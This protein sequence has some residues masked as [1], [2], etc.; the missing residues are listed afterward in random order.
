MKEEKPVVSIIVRTKD[1]L[2]LLKKALQSV[3]VQTYRPIEIILVNDG[4]C[5][6]D[7]NELKG[8]VGNIFLHY[9]RLEK[10]TGRAHAGN[11]GIENAKGEYIGFLDDDDEFYP[12][13]LAL[14]VSVLEQIDYK[15][16][17]TDSEL[18]FIE[19]DSEKKEFYGKEKKIFS[20]KDF[21]FA[22]L[23]VENYIPLISLLFKKEVLLSIGGFDEGLELFEDWDLLIR[24][25]ELYPFYHIK[26]VTSKYIQ[27]S[28][29]LQVARPEGYQRLSEIAYDKVTSKHKDKFTSDVVRHFREITHKLVRASHLVIEKDETISNKNSIILEKD[30]QITQ[31]ENILKEKDSQIAHL[32]SRMSQYESQIAQFEDILKGKDSQIVQYENILKG[33]DSQIA[34]YEDILKGKDSQIAQYEN[35]LEGKDSQIAQYENILKGKDSQIAQFEDILKGKDSQIVQFEDILKGKDS[36]IVQYENILKGKDS[37]IAQYENIL[38]GKDSQIAQYETRVSQYESQIVQFENILKG[39]NSQIAQ[40]ENILKG[41]DSQIAQYESRVA[42]FEN[43]IRMKDTQITQFENIIRGQDTQ[44]HKLEDRV[45]HLEAIKVKEIQI[46]QIEAIINEK[47]AFI[48]TM[49]NTIGWQLLVKFRKVRDRFLPLGSRRRKFYDKILGVFRI[50]IT[51]GLSGL[52]EKIKEKIHYKVDSFKEEINPIERTPIIEN[53]SERIKGIRNAMPMNNR[54]FD[55]VININMKADKLEIAK[56][57]KEFKLELIGLIESPKSKSEKDAR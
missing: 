34:Q 3:A 22:D 6:I 35:I 33:K 1:R 52:I 20:T 15:I 56:K 57:L 55:E 19:Y 12:E 27:W 51:R 10:N 30:S 28:K 54:A 17:Y 31:F 45:A 38:K 49:V 43:I 46:A 4:G 2:K 26:K 44:I 8:I 36:Q 42:Q 14:L 53:K 37:Q 48:T 18:A 47:D 29:D 40:Y 7:V 24:S 5:D 16:A 13:H 41:K 39:K 11:V 25:G 21:S 50:L 9:I 32:E 23:I